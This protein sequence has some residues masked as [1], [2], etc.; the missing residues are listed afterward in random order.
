MN[1]NSKLVA[2][3]LSIE[4]RFK[5]DF[6]KRYESKK[7]CLIPKDVFDT[8]LENVKVSTQNKST[9]MYTTTTCYHSNNHSPSKP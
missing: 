5:R 4:D 7:K 3:F 8:M 6:Y 1:L 9:K 2:M